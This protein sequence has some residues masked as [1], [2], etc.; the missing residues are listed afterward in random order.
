MICLVFW[1]LAC[2]EGGRTD[3]NKT[4]WKLNNWESSWDDQKNRASFEIVEFQFL[5]EQT[6]FE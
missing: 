6:N 5:F 4:N 3:F 2:N 1:I